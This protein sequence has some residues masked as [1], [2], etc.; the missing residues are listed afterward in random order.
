MALEDEF[1]LKESQIILAKNQEIGG[2]PLLKDEAQQLSLIYFP[3]S[4]SP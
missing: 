1:R 4:I 3:V 2:R